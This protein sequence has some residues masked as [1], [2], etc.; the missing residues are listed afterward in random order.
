MRIAHI[1]C[2]FPPYYG[3]MGNVAFQLANVLDSLG[4]ETTVF[5]PQYG[6][7][8]ATE[9]EQVEVKRLAPTFSYGNA[10]YLPQIQDELDD[11]CLCR[12]SQAR[13]QAY[14]QTD[15]DEMNLYC[16]ATGVSTTS[17][18]TFTVSGRLRFFLRP[19]CRDSWY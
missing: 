1:V 13:H 4:H 19:G 8:P 18:Q 10:A 9:K 5:T 14:D 11:L 3:G 7:T 6:L 17:C 16:C 12:N 2:T 15:P